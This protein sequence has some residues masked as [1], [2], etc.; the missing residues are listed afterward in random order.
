MTTSNPTIHALLVGINQ[1][2]SGAVP[3]LGGCVNDIDAMGQLLTDRFGVPTANISRLVDAEATHAAIKSAFETH[4]IAAARAWQ[5]AGKPEPSPAFL[6]HYSGHGSQA[7]DPTGS[8]PDGLDETIVPHDSRTA[9]IFDLKDWEL[10]ALVAQLTAITD[11]VTIVLDSCHSGSGTKAL[12]A[13]VDAVRQCPPDNRLEQPRR[14]DAAGT[15]EVTGASDWIAKGRHVLIA[16]CMDRELSRE[17][18]VPEEAG[19]ARG[20]DAD[21]ARGGG[22]T[23]GGG[24]AGAAPTVRK[25]GALTYYLVDTLAKMSPDRPLTYRELHERVRQLV[26]LRYADQTPQCE[27]DLDREVF[28]GARPL[29]DVLIRVIGVQGGLA[30][31]DGGL[32]HGLAVGTELAVHPP[33]TRRVADAG[34]PLARLEVVRAGATRSTCTI[35]PAEGGPAGDAPA[36][37]APAGG[38]PV[39]TVPVGAKAAITHLSYGSLRCRVAL[40]A[41][42]DSQIARGLADRVASD[43]AIPDVSGLLE[44]VAPDQ[45]PDIRVARQADGRLVIQDPAGTPLVAPYDPA[46]VEQVV[47][48]LAHIARF[49]NGRAL[50]NAD[51]G[52]ALD[53]RVTLEVFR[54]KKNAEGGFLFGADGLPEVEPVPRGADG[55]LMLT[56]VPER[57]DGSLDYALGDSVAFK[58]V[59]HHDKDVHVTLLNFAPS[60]GVYAVY[61]P[62][63]NQSA[64]Q[65][66][67]NGF[68]VGRSVD[69]IFGPEIP[70][71]LGGGMPEGRET[72]KLIVTTRPADFTVL[73]QEP[74]KSAFE[75]RSGAKGGFDSPL[76]ALLDQAAGS[77]T[78]ATIPRQR[79]TSD[80]D[81]S[82]VDLQALT[83][84]APDSSGRTVAPGAA[85]VLDYGVTITGPSGFSGTARLLTA[86][87]STRELG[88]DAVSKGGA[89]SIADTS[90]QPPP[91]LAA[92][93]SWFE[94]LPLGT[95]GSRGEPGTGALGQAGAVIELE[96]D[97]AGAW[98]SVSPEA[99]LR[100][101]LPEAVEAGTGL[102]ALGY[103]GAL[104][105]PVG[106]QGEGGR[107]IDVEWLPEPAPPG[108]AGEAT[109]DLKGAIRLYLFKAIGLPTPELGLR[110]SRFVAA[111]DVAAQALGPG[112]RAVAVGGG[113]LRYGPVRPGEIEA[114][115]RVGLFVH[116]FTSDTLWMADGVVRWLA[117]K[118]VHYDHVLTFDY[119]TAHTGMDANGEALAEALR[120]A[121]FG[122]GD[123]ASLDV[124]AHSMGT[125]VTRSMIER[126]GGHAFVDR[127]FLA[128]PPNEGTALA[129]LKQPIVW[130]LTLM[131]NHAGPTPPAMAASWALKKFSD[132]IQGMND[133]RPDSAFYKDLRA[134]GAQHDVV[135]R[136]LIGR[137]TLRGEAQGAW[138]RAARRLADD[139]DSLLDFVHQGDNDLAIAIASA[140]ALERLHPRATEAARLDIHEVPCDHFGYFATPEAQAQL[141]TWLG[142]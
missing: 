108:E 128:G 2:R 73:E 133:L 5:A 56:A 124:F 58:I 98:R 122:P 31:V 84:R 83:V 59:N 13:G 142:V 28:G 42:L 111:G 34:A 126:H 55:L 53:G 93:G 141:L 87:Q 129:S 78:K 131:L 139:A 29:R 117:S 27:G 50:R 134:P 57:A 22:G 121:G 40:A 106:W 44:I 11:N 39:A 70:V 123:G 100:V 26:N 89:A 114:G 115:Q 79:I 135:Y 64:V 119:E 130:L 118:G 15:R 101:G 32:A 20:G 66:N 88:I 36:A 125:Q 63:G 113:E 1:Y 6:F 61:P 38:A 85:T 67:P 120:R 68:F 17:M 10:G 41:E 90:L 116:G 23:R 3:N 62:P 47:A 136:V 92:F 4:L 52:S 104:Y 60:W 80:D 35:L 86:G 12:D 137:N 43:A 24:N 105:Y 7:P 77:G 94:P 91:G 65:P 138:E 140:R 127:A 25:Q 72:F 107:S 97:Q 96:S 132:N 99:P 48:D 76:Q 109:R 54:L 9:D 30:L 33:E 112:E 110:R 45:A 95:P 81:W 49:R 18:T 46:A 8:E 71:T 37:G 82:T 51:P 69:P 19:A 16:G 74:L 102:L 75:T 14:P 103:D 21:G